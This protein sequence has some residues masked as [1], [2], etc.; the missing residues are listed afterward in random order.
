MEPLSMSEWD[1]LSAITERIG[2]LKAQRNT[3]MKVGNLNAAAHF[4]KLANQAEAER[5]RALERL[6]EKLG[7]RRVNPARVRKTRWAAYGTRANQPPAAP[8]IR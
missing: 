5:E 1:E 8:V 2:A 4:F 3:A 6:I 7:D